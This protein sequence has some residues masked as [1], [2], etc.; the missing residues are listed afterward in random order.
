MKYEELFK[1]LNEKCDFCRVKGNPKA[2]TWTCNGKLDF[3]KEFCK[4]NKLNFKNVK[5]RLNNTGGFC[6]CEVLFNSAEKIKMSEVI[7]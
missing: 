6:D 5:K 4:T 7:K 1:Y 3:T 2:L